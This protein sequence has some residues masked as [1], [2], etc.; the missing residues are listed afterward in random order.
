MNRITRFCLPM[1]SALALLIPAISLAQQYVN[2]PT[3][4]WDQIY[5]RNTTAT[6]SSIA[7]EPAW[8]K[9]VGGGAGTVSNSF[10]A[11][12]DS[13]VF[14]HAAS[15][16]TADTTAAL[17]PS[18]WPAPSYR[19][20]TAAADT[21]WA[22]IMVRVQ[23]DTLSYGGT[24]Q[25]TRLDSL[26]MGAEY[27]TDGITWLGASGTPTRIF[28]ATGAGIASGGGGTMATL[29]AAAPI[30]GADYVDFPLQFTP[31]GTSAVPII[32]SGLGG[33]GFLIRF[34]F[35]SSGVNLG[36]WTV[37]LGHWTQQRTSSF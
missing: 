31:P 2:A 20:S 16:L 35:Y 6:T 15:A 25:H 26:Y 11:L 22:W 24:T 5:M 13:L 7:R 3:W 33:R 34:I 30:G 28:I 17:D 4:T 8:G 36:R 9:Y 1:L 37:K 14:S 18:Q 12:T 32:N 10:G 23:Q 27:S 21:G 29:I 19:L